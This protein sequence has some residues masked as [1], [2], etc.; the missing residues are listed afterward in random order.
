MINFSEDIYPYIVG[1]ALV[2]AIYGVI[3]KLIPLLFR[4]AMGSNAAQ[5]VVN[6]KAATAA[7]G[8]VKAKPVFP[9][10][11]RE[12]AGENAMSALGAAKAE[13]KAMPVI[14]GGGERERDALADM[15]RH[16]NTTEYY[17]NKADANP[18]PFA[19]KAKPRMPKHWAEAGPFVEDDQPFLVKTHPS[20]FKPIVTLA[21]IPA[22][23]PAEIP[24]FL[25]LGSWNAVPD[26]DV[27]VALLRKW[28]REYGAEL[29]ALRQDCMDIRVARKPASREEALA[30]AREHLKFCAT[31]ETIAQ[32]AA[33]LMHL[34]WWHFYW[35]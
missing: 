12:V 23:S 25:K 21:F 7:M 13:G 35:D 5:A 11:F 19:S 22:P 31:G 8:V 26:A 34:N 28:Q 16:R 24:A 33:A 29:V 18:D 2:L 20:G 9:F 17:L 15:M 1:L 10:A 32:S 6:S 3:Y 4:K 30:L 27:F 14:I